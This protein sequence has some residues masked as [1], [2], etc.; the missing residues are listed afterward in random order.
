MDDQIIQSKFYQLEEE[1]RRLHSRINALESRI[2]D[3]EHGSDKMVRRGELNIYLRQFLTKEQADEIYRK[4]T[5]LDRVFSAK[6]GETNN[7]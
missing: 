4:K 3:H 7:G 5:M 2:L 6:M 1:N